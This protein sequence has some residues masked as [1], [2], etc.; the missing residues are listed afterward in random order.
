MLRYSPA[1]FLLIGYLAMVIGLSSHSGS[2][3]DG[4]NLLFVL[5]A[6]T[7]SGFLPACVA[8]GVALILAGRLDQRWQRLLPLSY[9]VLCPAIAVVGYLLGGNFDF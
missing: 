3:P 1:L 4:D 2:T 6:G 7:L 9:A 5:V 8:I